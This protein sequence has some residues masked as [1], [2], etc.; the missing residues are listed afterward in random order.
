MQTKNTMIIAVA[1]SAIAIIAGIVLIAVV[2]SI[3]QEVEIDTIDTVETT[4]EATPGE[5][6]V[7]PEAAT[8]PKQ[9]TQTSGGAQTKTTA[10]QSDQAIA[11]TSPSAGD[12]L[13]L[14]QN[15][16]IS[17]SKEG[18][19]KGY[20]Y[21]ADASTKAVI[22]WINSETG[23]R[24]TSYT[25]DTRNLFLTRY[26][27]NKKTVEPG[28]YIIGVGFESKQ[29]PV[30]SGVFEIIYPSQATIDEYNISI[31]DFYATPNSLTVK[32]GSKLTFA[33]ND[34]ITLKI[35]TGS[36]AFSVAPGSSY[37]FDTS[38]LFPGEYEFYAE[39]YT[40][41]RVRVSVQ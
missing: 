27:P 40:T 22:G 24:Q 2:P 12:K 7:A 16:T 8:P 21:L 37:T 28:K 30:V 23:P 17:W 9:T 18:G 4:P 31:K 11:V 33:N 1:I 3:P 38:A 15:H 26:S 13:I 6:E 5:T 34:A 29:T 10:P 32:K 39:Q 35:M 19:F 36:I 41:M 25:W 20:V 14:G